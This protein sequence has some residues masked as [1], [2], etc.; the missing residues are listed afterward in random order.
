MHEIQ[1]LILR[2]YPG[3]ERKVPFRGLVCISFWLHFVINLD[4]S[5]WRKSLLAMATVYQS[6]VRMPGKSHNAQYV[7]AARI[8]K[9]GLAIIATE[10]DGLGL[11]IVALDSFSMTIIG[12]LCC[13]NASQ[14]KP[15][16]SRTTATFGGLRCNVCINVFVLSGDDFSTAVFLPLLK[17]NT[18]RV[19]VFPC[20]AHQDLSCVCVASFGD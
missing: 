17:C 6:G 13:C 4:Q 2:C 16:S 12:C 8:L 5:S 10:K 20:C 18:D 3:V 14:R 7:G 1:T 19:D 11:S 15:T 9:L